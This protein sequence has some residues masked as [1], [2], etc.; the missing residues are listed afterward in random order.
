M[1]SSTS[2]TRIF[3]APSIFLVEVGPR[4]LLVSGLR[5]EVSGDFPRVGEIPGVRTEI[6]QRAATSTERKLRNC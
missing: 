5:R 6:P 2:Q 4:A 1:P 3:E